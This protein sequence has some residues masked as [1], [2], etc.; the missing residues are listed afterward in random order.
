MCCCRR[1]NSFFLTSALFSR[2][3]PKMSVWWVLK[4]S[5]ARCWMVVLSETT[6]YKTIEVWMYTNLVR[7]R[8]QRLVSTLVASS[9]PIKV[10]ILEMMV[11]M[12]GGAPILLDTWKNTTTTLLGSLGLPVCMFESWITDICYIWS[13]NCFSFASRVAFERIFNSI[14]IISQ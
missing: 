7:S 13:I 14:N 4:C 3:R 9:M 1:L 11:F 6:S 12:S 10:Q 8:R 5:S 2:V